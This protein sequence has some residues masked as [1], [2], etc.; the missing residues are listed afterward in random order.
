MKRMEHGAGL[1]LTTSEATARYYARGGGQV[2]RFELDPEIVALGDTRIDA[3]ILADFVRDAPRLRHRKEI[4]ADL[5]RASD[6]S[7]EARSSRAIMAATLVNLL[8][9]YKVLT[10]SM[11]PAVAQFYVSQG[12]DSDWIRPTSSND[13]A[14]RWLVLFNLAKIRRIW[15]AYSRVTRLAPAR[16]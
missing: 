1:Y 7:W 3:R 4:L 11:G 6:R 16:S 10:G 9:H 2:L 15:F 8:H 5:S 13:P 14:E 12:I